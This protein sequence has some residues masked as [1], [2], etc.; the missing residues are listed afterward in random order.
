MKN[1]NSDEKALR[2]FY[3]IVLAKDLSFVD[4]VAKVLSLGCSYLQLKCG[5]V[6]YVEGERYTVL[7]VHTES[8]TYQIQSGDVFELGLT[9]CKF[10]LEQKEPLAFNH[11]AISEIAHHPSYDAL[12]LEAYLGAATYLNSETFGTVNFSSIEP[13]EN[14][15]SDNEK[16]F[17][18]LIAEWVSTQLDISFKREP[19]LESYQ[20]MA[21]RLHSAPLVGIELNK[22][23]EVITWNNSATALLGWGADQVMGKHP[24]DWP[25]IG[26]A[27]VSRL[28]DM[29]G[30]ITGCSEQGCAFYCDIIKNDGNLISTEW[31]LSCAMSENNQCERVRAQILDITN[32]VRSESELLRKNA[33]YID[34]YENAPD[35]YL[36][37][38]QTGNI[39]SANNICHRALGYPKEKLV[40]K[41]YWNLI[42]KDDVRR[43]RRL[44]DVAFSG[45]VE[46]LE[47]EASLL[48]KEGISVR[49]HQR[50]RIIQAKKGFPREL[51]IIARDITERKKGQVNRVLHLE[52]QRDEISLEVQHRI[53]NSLQAVIGLLTVSMDA[54]PELKPLL[55]NS[56][57]Q[58]N[59]ISI[60]NGLIL[61]GKEDVDLIS[62]LE[63]L[64]SESSRLF[65]YEI[66]LSKQLNNK[67]TVLLVKEEIISISLILT[68]LLINALKH[69]G[70]NANNENYVRVE[71]QAEDEFAKINIS[72]SV[73]AE[74][75]NQTEAKNSHLGVAMVQSLLPPQ[76]VT[77]KKSEKSDH[78][79]VDLTMASP[80]IIHH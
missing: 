72:N 10:T 57:A 49:T 1:T 70:Q 8:D 18:Q 65:A 6:S 38:D 23:F 56:I 73:A 34:L 33:L 36:S 40:G 46:E 53:K 5:I 29:L 69:H 51:R 19:S 79:N 21:A 59:A 50:I 62:L 3:S 31:F 12:K 13:R 27:D 24:K 77:L 39:L 20:E 78:Y 28:I 52:Q 22:S 75:S 76:G 47:I 43:I 26:N 58:V 61:D 54:H 64:L 80:V 30:T 74:H 37:L 68:E 45:D 17:V 48:T 63:N 42:H 25:L 16:Y 35:M 14:E 71:I 60:V 67:V 9:Y 7:H 44:I 15:F 11:V 2:E 55:T 32:R 4:Q 41:P 66:K